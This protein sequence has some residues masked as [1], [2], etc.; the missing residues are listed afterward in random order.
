[1]EQWV[2]SVQL[3]ECLDTACAEYTERTLADVD[4]LWSGPYRLDV[5]EDGTIATSWYVAA[6]GHPVSDVTLVSAVCD[7]DAC[8]LTD[9]G[10]FRPWDITY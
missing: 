9:L 3:I 1:M 10:S 6:T 4:Y 2:G 5:H 7:H 8:D